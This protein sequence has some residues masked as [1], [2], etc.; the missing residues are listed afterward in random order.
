MSRELLSDYRLSPSRFDEMFEAPQTPRAHWR[1]MFEQLAATPADLMKARIQTV[2]RQVRENGVSYNVYADPEGADRP[3]EL[4]V[5]PLIIPP[6]EW[7]ALAA[8]VAQRAQLLDLILG[9][10][11]G[12]QALLR[13]GLLPATLVYGHAA[14]L[15]PCR[16]AKLPGDVRLHLYAADLARAPDGRW[17]VM[18]DRTQA[19]SGAGYALENRLVISRL[20]PDLF[21]DLKV[22]HLAGFFAT[23]R[24]SLAGWA[25]PGDGVPLTVLLTP[26]PYNET[27]F[28]H[29][30]LARY[31]GFPLVEGSDLTVRE[32]K[33]WL[34]TLSGLRRVHA[35]LRR[36]DGD[37]CDPL[38]L[39]P[40]STLG[41]PGL[42]EAMRRGNVLVANA[43]GSSILESGML[44]GFLPR[45]CERLL[46][47]PLK[48]ASVATWWCG[49]PAALEDALTRLDRLVIK[50]AF[51]Q[52]GLEPVFG[53]TL[54][55]EERQALVARMRARPRDYVAQELVQLSQ[56]PVWDDAHPRRLAAR[57][58]GLRVYACASPKGYVVMPGG[59]TR[60]ANGPDARV[61]S[62]QRGGASKDTW[63]L[64]AGPV[65]QF[66]LLHRPSTPQD[67]VRTGI[68]LSSR[69]VE[70]L[71]WF[72]RH[73]E[74]CDG[75][76]RLLRVALGRMI[77]ETAGERE[78]GWRGIAGL[79]A[80]A[81]I[82]NG[83]GDTV[84]ALAL[85]AAVTDESKPGLAANLRLLVRSASHLREL[86]SAD[87]WRT[88]NHMM[89]SVARRRGQPLGL[90]DALSELDGVIASLVTL[91]GFALDGMT[92]DHA[93]R[94]LS[95]G[96][97]IE[98]LQW[99]C[100]ALTQALSAPREADLGWL[101]E[102]ADSTLTYRARYMGAPD[103]LP[104]L[105]LLV[106]DETNPRSVAFQLLGLRDY[107]ARVAAAVGYAGEERMEEAVLALRALDPATD[108]QHG[109]VRLARLLDGWHGAA[110]RLS[111]QLGLRFFVHAGEINR[112]TV[113]T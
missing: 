19:P 41:I 26:G 42:V 50:P 43:L 44:L 13:E 40:D 30:Y 9:D 82:S 7:R 1:A 77:D 21:R 29:V 37:Y 85:R 90:A 99:M 94:F 97:R 111:E 87:N 65:S 49:E 96:R 12:E 35:I 103:W 51:P 56:A 68:N 46:G 93:W 102:L 84:R 8:A 76:A 45:L 74:R 63:V 71:F 88:L 81:G 32:G 72:G 31:L 98:R 6:E 104:V 25:P 105:D 67:L 60:V 112:Q 57:A 48:L 16:G 61:V 86:M 53:E 54:R 95:M 107:V 80:R 109:S 75:L 55:A 108:L 27:Y 110:Y 89:R 91:A 64:C 17:W 33:V 83:A 52:L 113:A 3:W 23:L 62:M 106:R 70:H 18:S 11:Y 69:V 24:D 92:R 39:R 20:Y 15:R 58:T 59:L 22:D 47:E 79:L 2:Q 66:T 34:K 5:L 78:S 38:E 100:T 4:D 28:E 10:I 101:L 36:L 14:Y 73:A